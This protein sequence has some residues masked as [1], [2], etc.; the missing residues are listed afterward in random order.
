MRKMSKKNIGRTFKTF[1]VQYQMNFQV[2]L[3]NMYKD[4]QNDRGSTSDRI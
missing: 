3:F 1:K 4:L 2:L